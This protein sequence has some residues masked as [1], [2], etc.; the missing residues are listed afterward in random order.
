MAVEKDAARLDERFELFTRSKLASLYDAKRDV[1]FIFRLGGLKIM[2]KK[3]VD[4]NGD[5]WI[6][7]EPTTGEIDDVEIEDFESAFIPKY[8]HLRS[9]WI[10]AKAFQ[11][12]NNEPN[13][14][15]VS[16]IVAVIRKGLSTTL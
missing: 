16:L 7:Q 13:R 5:A 11:H 15:L 4:V 3:N 1:L 6:R 2:Q 9:D 8:P 12:E 10:R 14:S